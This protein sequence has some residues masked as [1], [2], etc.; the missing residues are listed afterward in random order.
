MINHFIY[1]ST[2]PTLIIRLLII[3]FCLNIVGSYHVVFCL[4][5]KIQFFSKGFQFLVIFRS[6]RMQHHLFGAWNIRSFLLILVSKFLLV[7]FLLPMLL[8][9]VLISV[10]LLF[11]MEFSN[12]CEDSKLSRRQ[13]D[14][15]AWHSKSP[16]IPIRQGKVWFPNP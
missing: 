8:L 10:R 12:P 15:L 9:A 11:L 1:F 4:F 16:V 13:F 2:L 7:F 14:R 6:S 3:N 5:V